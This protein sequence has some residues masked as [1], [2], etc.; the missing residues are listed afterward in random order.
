MS[1]RKRKRR[2]KKQSAVPNGPL[3]FLD[4]IDCSERVAAPK[5]SM[6]YGTTMSRS[7]SDMPATES[8]RPA[9]ESERPA[10]R[11]ES[12]GGQRQ[13][14]EGSQRSNW[15]DGLGRQPGVLEC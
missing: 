8:R 10:D 13:G 9:R 7:E 15:P 2:R 11:F 14:Q 3:K 6:T 12:L 1:K 4:L 5:G